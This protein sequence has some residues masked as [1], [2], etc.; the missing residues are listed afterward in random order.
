[1][2]NVLTI[3]IDLG[4]D[5]LKLSYAY[6]KPGKPT[7]VYG[8]IEDS[9]TVRHVAVPAVAYYDGANWIFGNDIEKGEEKP[10]ITVVKIK[11]LLSLLYPEI[12]KGRIVEK[13]G[14][15][16]YPTREYFYKHQHFPKFFFPDRQRN[17][18]N[19]SNLIAEERTF[20]AAG[21]TPQKVC[22]M[23]FEY[24]YR[25]VMAGIARVETKTK[26]HFDEVKLALVHPAMVGDLYVEELTSL[27]KTAFGK[28]PAKVMNSGR[29]LSMFAWERGAVGGDDEILIFDMGEDTLSVL[30]C[31]INDEGQVVVEPAADHSLPI[32][33]GGNDVDFS[34]AGYIENSIY[35]RETVGSPSKPDA[36]HIY[37]E[38]LQSKQYLFLK[39]IKK[40]KLLLS[41]PSLEKIFSKGVPVSLHR[42]LYIQRRITKEEL[43]KSVG[44]SDN[45]GIAKKI[46]DYV[47]KEIKLP[48]NSEVKN[49]F[50]TGG[51]IETCGLLDYLKSAIRKNKADIAVRTFEDYMDNGDSTVIQT[52]E[53]S[54]YA[55]SVGAAIIALKNYDVRA[56]L[57][58]SYGT[59]FTVDR[60]KILQILVGRGYIF[61]ETKSEKLWAGCGLDGC[62]QE[63]FFSVRLSKSTVKKRRYEGDIKY[64]SFNGE[65][66]LCIGEP[67]SEQRKKVEKR[68]QLKNISGPD[69]RIICSYN[70]RMIRKCMPKIAMREGVI[71]TPRSKQM[72][73][74]VEKA[75]GANRISVTYM[76]GGTGYV[77]ERNINIQLVGIKPFEDDND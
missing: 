63:E 25:I 64:L 62:V 76:D 54:V 2:A 67:G 6:L 27:V 48:I 73:P 19:F 59:W 45:S 49:V 15:E 61:D 28:A 52:Y 38:G 7:V 47:L 66:Y 72:T 24:A 58:Y 60:V 50:L 65:T 33:I 20:T 11:T 37:E 30:K 13:N 23:F 69:A 46:L 57:S 36:R 14:K 77:N 43:K 17:L 74:Y 18:E 3:G 16:V 9:D 26:I 55:S 42:E 53:D 41:I 44:I 51:L 4:R 22:K 56:G 40:A 75:D 1:M 31:F 10:F 21:Y 29:A 12:R 8:K 34:I 70:G 35:G 68:F 39:E 5:T 71:T 32:D